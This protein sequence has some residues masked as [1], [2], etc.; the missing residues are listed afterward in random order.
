MEKEEFLAE[1]NYRKAKLVSNSKLAEIA[2]EIEDLKIEIQKGN[3]DVLPNYTKLI[4]TL[5][6]S[7][8]WI[9]YDTMYHEAIELE[10]IIAGSGH[11][12]E[13]IKK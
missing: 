5:Y 10:F 12:L 9:A 3:M 7:E 11:D 2:H 6:H 1:L 4:D 13:W 8:E